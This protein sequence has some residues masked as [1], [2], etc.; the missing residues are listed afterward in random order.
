MTERRQKFSRKSQPSLFAS[1]SPTASFN[2]HL[3]VK[4]NA[5]R[6]IRD[7]R[8]SR[9]EI[10]EEMAELL[11]AHVSLTMLDN[12]TAETKDKH[13]FPLAFTRAFCFVTG[14]FDLLRLAVEPLGYRLVNKTEATCVEIGRAVVQHRETEE[15]I[16]E[17]IVQAREGSK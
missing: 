8:K 7:C 2:D 13:R 5:A 10:A 3:A 15:R 6:A 4:A 16:Q 17:L 14:N 11:G 12:W 9:Q 1:V